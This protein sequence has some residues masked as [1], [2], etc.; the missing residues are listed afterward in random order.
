[1]LKP[2]PQNERIKRDY[3]IYLKEAKGK[4]ES[5]I[6]AIRKALLRFEAHTKS[7]EFKSFRREQAIAFKAHLSET[8]R[9]GSKE[10]LSM[11]TQLSTLNAL[12]EFFIWLYGQKGCGAKIHIHDVQYFSLTDKE[13]S[14]AKA[15][16][17]PV[18]PSLEQIMHTINSMPSN[19]LIERRNRALI[20]F[21]ILTGIRD[22]ALA[23]L[24]LRHIEPPLVRQEPD[25]VKTK[26]SKTIN[27]FFFP[28]DDSLKT[29]VLDWL[30]ELKTEQL[31]SHNDPLFP[32]TKMG[33]TAQFTF[34]PIGLD[35]AHWAN[36][37]PIR[38]IFKE[39][40]LYAGLPYFNPHSFRHT[41]G[42][43]AQTMCKTGEELK[44][45]SQNLGHENVQTTL[46]SYGKIDTKRQGEV[47]G[48]IG[49]SNDNPQDVINEMRRLLKVR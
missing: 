21:T 25:R 1:M 47:I 4:S 7:K 3:F 31:F 19:T 41:L 44:A 49:V 11:S 43:L 36:A 9:E 30:H 15:V 34:T 2:H 20:A 38:S 42:H 27:T 28:L 37:S 22:N 17:A 39:A 35:K 40:F 18:F 12:K 14:I 32:K 33:Q 10:P 24:S 29:I 13:I 26:F 46:T 45:W 5:T 8:K 48:R 23:T 16:K 6:D